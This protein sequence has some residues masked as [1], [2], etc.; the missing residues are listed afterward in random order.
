MMLAASAPERPQDFIPA[1][2]AP[3]ADRRRVTANR[4]G[5]VKTPARAAPHDDGDV[6]AAE[7]AGNIAALVLAAGRSRR[8]GGVNKLLAEIHGQPMVKWVVDAALA[9]QARPV[10]V[11]TGHERERLGAVLHGDAAR[12]VHNPDYASGLASSL[13]SGILALPESCKGVI[14]LLADMPLIGSAHIDHILRA[15]APSRGRSIVVPQHEG[16]RG[17]PVL[18]ARLFFSEIV[19]L[20]GDEGAR[21]LLRQHP[22]AVF[23]L[24]MGDA[25]VLTDIDTMESLAALRRQVERTYP[26]PAS[27]SGNG[28][29]EGA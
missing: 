12:L 16:V 13:R 26:T 19:A 10:L 22:E 4:A 24:A 5:T 29:C 25:A 23:D 15:F 28:D 9:S 2:S 3:T 8:M 17:N 14:V 18:W 11:V 21:R 27:E 6:D 1:D 20:Q 7:A